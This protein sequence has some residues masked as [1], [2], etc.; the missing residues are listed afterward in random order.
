[1]DSLEHR[2]KTEEEGS[3]GRQGGKRHDAIKTESSEEFWERALQKSLHEDSPCSDKRQ[4]SFRQF[5][6]HQAEGP[7]EAVALAEGFLLSQMEA[8]K[9]EGQGPPKAEEGT[10]DAK[11]TSLPKGLQRDQSITSQGSGM[12]PAMHSG[13]PLLGDGME[14]GQ[15][16]MSFED[17]AVYFTKEEWALLDRD[18]RNL[19]WEVMMENYGNVAYLAGGQERQNESRPFTPYLEEKGH[20]RRRTTEDQARKNCNS[21]PPQSDDLHEILVQEKVVEGKE[22]AQGPMFGESFSMKSNLNAHWQIHTGE[23]PYK[24]LECGKNFTWSSTLATHQRIHTEEEPYKC[25][26]CGKNFST[27]AVLIRHLRIH[28]GEKPYVCLQCGKSFCQS[29]SLTR[30]QR[31]HTGEKPYKC[32]VCGK[33]FSAS[34]VLS[35]HQR[36]HTGEKPFQ[37]SECG[38][39]FCQRAK[40]IRHQAV[41]TGEKPYTCLQCGKGCRDRPDLISHQRIHTGEKPYQCSVCGKGYGQSSYLNKHQRIHTGEKPYK[42]SECGKGFTMNSVLKRHQRIHTGEKPYKCSDSDMS[43]CPK[44]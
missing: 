20:Q 34:S 31:I 12:V 26:V 27:A 39:N 28:T 35:N 4:Q 13:S 33:S 41:H 42:C 44:I 25:S 7:R 23:K 16:L 5:L 2:G 6:Y 14:P 29:S 21:S 18:Q 30:H 8:K 10:P 32:S 40:L 19:H 3:A 9:Q 11:E 17:V 37:C 24:C 15:C 1:M 22:W 36:I 43:F 38:K